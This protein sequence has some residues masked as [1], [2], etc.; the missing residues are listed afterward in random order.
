MNFAV[1]IGYGFCF[2]IGLILSN[3]VMTKLFGMGF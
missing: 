2:G 3:A 1:Q